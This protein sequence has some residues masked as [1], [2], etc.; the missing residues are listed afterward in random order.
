MSTT[1]ANFLNS[2][3]FDVG[4][5]SHSNTF[6]QHVADE[7]SCEYSKLKNK[8]ERTAWELIYQ[9]SKL[10]TLEEK[11]IHQ[12][13]N[14]EDLAADLNIALFYMNEGKKELKKE[15]EKFSRDNILLREESAK[16]IEEDD[17]DDEDDEEES[18]RRKE[19][20]QPSDELRMLVL[21]LYRMRLSTEQVRSVL[22]GMMEEM[23]I[24]ELET[25]A[26]GTLVALRSDLGPVCDVLTAIKLAR[27]KRW[28][29]LGLELGLG[30]DGRDT[31]CVSVIVQYGEGENRSYEKL[32]L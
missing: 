29:Q 2:N 18:C 11:T 12:K 7:L 20:N 23:N 22:E 6:V 17:Q 15:I 10:E 4:R 25:P 31:T 24:D 14:I 9:K 13:K 32:I 21:K 3:I 30:H 19:G 1:I 28:L 27:A 5:G 16:F 26:Y 8:E